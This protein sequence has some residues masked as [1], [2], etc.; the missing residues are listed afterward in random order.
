MIHKTLLRFH[1]HFFV[2]QRGLGHRA[3]VHHAFAAIDEA[4]FVKLNEHLLHATG[5]VR[6]HR[7]AFARPIARAAELLELVDDDVAVLFFPHPDA[8]EKF[9]AAEIVTGFFLLLLELLFHHH[10]RGDTGVVGARQPEDF[11]AVHARLAAED[12]LDG[13]VE[14]VAHVEHAGDVRRRDDDGERRLGGRRVGGEATLLQPEGVPFVLN[15][16]RLVSFGKF[17]HK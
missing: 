5:I 1:F 6:V 9:L 7:E 10:L 12:V 2:R 14:D 16:L 17:R 11:L 8:L 15:G 4:F 13:V 3:P